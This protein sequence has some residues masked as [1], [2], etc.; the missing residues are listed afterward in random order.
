MWVRSN[1]MSKWM[2]IQ[3]ITHCILYIVHSI[4]YIALTRNT[5]LMTSSD[6]SNKVAIIPVKPPNIQSQPICHNLHLQKIGNRIVLGLFC[7]GQFRGWIRDRWRFCQSRW[8]NWWYTGCRDRSSNGCIGSLWR[9]IGIFLLTCFDLFKEC[10]SEGQFCGGGG[11]QC[12]CCRLTGT[13]IHWICRCL[14][15]SC[16]SIEHSCCCIIPYHIWQPHEIRHLEHIRH[17]DFTCK[18]HTGRFICWHK[19]KNGCD[20]LCPS[21]TPYITRTTTFEKSDIILSIQ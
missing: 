21:Y 20:F 17:L 1:L 7:K 10:L 11:S 4:L 13:G 2:N 6:S 3:W 19:G 18:L 5:N 8:C 15:R 16:C 14:E 9:A 12:C